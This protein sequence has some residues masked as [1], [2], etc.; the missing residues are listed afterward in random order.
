[1]NSIDFTVVIPTYNGS[2]RLPSVLQR[3]QEQKGLEH[4]EWEIIIVDN[5]ST[6]ETAK[7]VS[8]YQKSWKLQI[9]LRYA[10]EA[11]Q[12]AGF[13]R[14]RGIVQAK[15]KIVGFLDDDNLPARNWIIE[16]YKFADIHPRAG[17][18]ASQIH[19]LFERDPGEQ[20]KPILFYLAITERGEYPQ[21]YEPRK[22]GFPPSA[23]LVVRREA[24][25]NNVPDRLFLSGRVGS[26]ML[27]SE[28]AEV[29]F[30]IHQA[31]WEIWYNP[32][33]E[34]EHIIPSWRLE[35]KYLISLMRGVGL[36]RHHLRMLLL[37]SW[38]RPF[39]FFMY[40]VNDIR[41]LISHFFRY[42]KYLDNNIF[43]ACEMER[44][45]ATLISPFFLWQVRIKRLIKQ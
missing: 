4:L 45:R 34:V 20:I 41:K 21:I 35:K 40:F 13:A 11:K 43:A 27:G 1:M 25:L 5:N 32:A 17:A 19:A 30:Y 15:G 6:D 26:S 12:G 23:G 37:K 16:A 8:D 42:R 24:W 39:A 29:L 28:D 9:P 3:L 2:K 7:V 38:Q 14:Q 44:L 22:K 18:Y 10:F 33:M 31:K 36:A